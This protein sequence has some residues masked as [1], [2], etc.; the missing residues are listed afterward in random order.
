M[1]A[2]TFGGRLYLDNTWKGWDSQPLTWR[3]MSLELLTFSLCDPD[4]LIWLCISDENQWL[5]F[6]SWIIWEHESTPNGN[7]WTIICFKKNHNQITFS[8]H[9]LS[10]PVEDLPSL[11]Y[12]WQAWSC[13]FLWPVKS[14]QKWCVLCPRRNSQNSVVALPCTLCHLRLPF[15]L[16]PAAQSTGKELQLADS[17]G[18]RSMEEE[19][20][21]IN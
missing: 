8:L 10:P 9:I 14:E 21:F 11:H 18:S 12:Q 4:D 17:W 2:L 15:S 13:S 3:P 5:K 16:D 7:L 20:V 6:F 19:W 1:E